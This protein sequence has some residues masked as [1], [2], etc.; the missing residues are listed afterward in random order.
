MPEEHH[1]ETTVVWTGNRGEGTTSYTA[2]SRDHQLRITGKP[3]VDCSSDPAFRGDASKHNPEELLVAA[4]S[5]CHMLWY[6]HLCAIA[7]VVV[8]HYVDHAR[9]QM[10]LEPGGSGRFTRVVLHPHVT[11]TS[12]DPEIA[13]SLHHE[14]HRM[15]F[16]ANSINFVVAVEPEVIEH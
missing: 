12:G 10:K 16:I 5:S 1:Y 4:L 15:C 8:S 3:S 7:G 2:Y 11:I 9:G 14:A 13:R 6:L